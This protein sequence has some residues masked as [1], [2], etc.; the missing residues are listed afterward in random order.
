M[1]TTWRNLIVEALHEDDKFKDLL[2]V[3]IEDGGLDKVFDSG[4][5]GTEGVPFTAWSKNWVYFPIQ[6]DGAEWVGKAPRNPCPIRLEH[7][8][9]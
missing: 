3:E 9:G 6:Y 7:Q 1:N 8:G 2:H 5:G 4:F